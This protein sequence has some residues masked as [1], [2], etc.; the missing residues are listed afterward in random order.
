MNTKYF[1]L[2]AA[3]L[4]MM[5]SCNGWLSEDGPMTNRVEDF[6]TSAQTAVQVVNAAYV[7]LMWEYQDTYFSEF[8]IGDILSDDA[9]KGGQNISDMSD[10]YDLENFKAI[11]NN[12]LVQSY[13]RA[14]YQGIARA[15]LAIEQVAAMDV[16][17][18]LTADLKST[19]V[20]Q[21]RFLRALYYFR[22]VRLWGGVP[23]TTSP[24]YSSEDWIQPRAT[25]DEVYSQII[26]DLEYAEG[27]LPKKSDYSN[28]DLGRATQGAA[29][30][31]LLKVNL[32]WGD[33]K[34]NSS[35]SGAD[36]KY[37]EAEE[38][39]ARFITDQSGEY[40]LCPVYADN[41]TLEGENGPES[42]FEVQY[43]AEGTSDYGQG[44]GFSRGTFTTILTRSRSSYFSNAGWGFNHPTQNL[45]DEYEALD[46]RRDAT[47]LN[48]TDDEITT[49]SDEIYLGNRYLTLKR[50]IMTDSGDYMT[51]DHASRSPI[52]RIEIRLA[53]VYL[54]YAEACL[55]NGNTGPVKEYL[56]KVRSRAR[57][58]NLI[59]PEFPG[60]SVPDY[61]N[62]YQ[63]HSLADTPEDLEMA[64]R[65]ERRVELAMESHRWY[66]LC[67][68][69]IAKEVMEAY[70]K[71]ETEQAR[72]HMG[73]FI[74][75]K[76]ELLPIPD[77]EVRLGSLI[78]NNG[79]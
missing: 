71:T 29:Q 64:I 18:D 56:E 10:A 50:T 40:F 7:P 4:P 15:N 51:L 39:G 54:M 22:L 74:K 12:T 60:Y 16:D 58:G 26:E 33:Y 25:V 28:E 45:Y 69:G 3:S 14:Q 44:N 72:S 68:W 1:L 52:N 63:M 75:G 41:F 47:I 27:V 59:L 23:L 61:R 70:K 36:D 46:P 21:A 13:Y 9:L 73:S 62:D 57:H 31:M 55:R 11:S 20:G 24:I 37:S 30:A 66:D 43:M 17:E 8:F 19:L 5:V 67:R 35:A 77:E 53:D 32:Y 6:F 78:Q 42:V 34:R 2:C 49:P 76:H 38:W 79:Y 48:L 65:H